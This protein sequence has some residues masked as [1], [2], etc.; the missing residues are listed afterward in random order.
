MP[1]VVAG[2]HGA[3]GGGRM[4]GNAGGECRQLY[5][6][7]LQSVLALAPHITRKA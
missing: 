5:E 4:G 7:S 3:C 2:Q 6:K 1:L